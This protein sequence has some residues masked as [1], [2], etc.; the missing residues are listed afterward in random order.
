MGIPTE[1]GDYSATYIAWSNAWHTTSFPVT[2]GEYKLVEWLQ[3][4]KTANEYIDLK[5]KA[6]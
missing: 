2:N 5:V 6:N 4:T 3:D 1:A